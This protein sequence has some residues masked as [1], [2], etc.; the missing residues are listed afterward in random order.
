MLGKLWFEYTGRT[1]I[2]NHK[3]KLKCILEFKPYSYFRGQINRVEGYICDANDNKLAL[4]AGK[5][6]SYFYA[7]NDIENSGKKYIYFF[8]TCDLI[9]VKFTEKIRITCSVKVSKSE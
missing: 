8:N 6:D 5:W 4:L 7:T 3:L 2:I 9:K 1:E